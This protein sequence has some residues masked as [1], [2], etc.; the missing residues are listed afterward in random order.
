VFWASKAHYI[1][2]QH[3][4]PRVNLTV[5]LRIEQVVAKVFYLTF[6]CRFS[7][8][9]SVLSNPSLESGKTL[10][11]IGSILLIFSAIPVVG[12]VGIILLAI[13]LKQL[14]EY[15]R[16]ENIF[17]S[18]IWGV[19]FGIIGIIA[20]SVGVFGSIFTS[21]ATSVATGSGLGIIFGALAFIAVLVITFIFFILMA[22]NFRRCLNAL[23]DRSGE[24]L[25]RTAGTLLFYGAFL[26]II[27]IGVVLIFI[28][29]LIATIAFFSIKTRPQPAAYAAPPPTTQP[30][31]VQGTRYCP[32][33]GSPA[34]AS[35]TFCPHC[36]KQLPPP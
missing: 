2:G 17:R 6:K 4:G 35:A 26:T 11:G 18:A 27:I 14:S 33:C 16:D 5:G 23:A 12:I 3:R 20:L 7:R 31:I 22:V 1:K 8:G 24:S 19:I 15:Y 25:F 30:P 29:W 10:A 21:V 9:T 36:G 13:G 34:D 32:N 28:A